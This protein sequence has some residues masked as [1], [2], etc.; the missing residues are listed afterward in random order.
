[1]KITEYAK[2]LLLAPNLEDKLLPPPKQWIDDSDQKSIRIETP[3]RNHKL[4]FSDKKIKIPRLEHLNLESN[5]GLTLHHFANHEL[6]AIELF[7]W[8]ILAFP[9]AQKSVRNGWVKTIEE[10]Q[11]HFKMYLNRMSEFGIQFGDIPL[12][13]I[14]WKQLDQFQSMESF[15]AVM[16]LSFEGA[17]LD[18]SQ[19]YAKVFSYFGDEKTSEI[20]IYIFEDEIKHVK[21]GVRAF[22]KS[23]PSEKNSW[24]HYLSLIQF[25]FTPRRAKGYLFFPE[26]R[27]LSGLDAN[28]VK[29][30]AEYEDEYTG[31][32]NL[33]S[34]KKF[35]LG[36][37][38]MRKKQA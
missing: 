5:R 22:E 26:T 30:L 31:R 29:Q 11:T 13:Y 28:F 8:A 19:V 23:I 16:S 37:E 7:A 38:L 35:G 2:H 20:M 4:Q 33:E 18:Y 21:R 17:N 25:P 32:V 3:G 9:D 14:F 34:V 24:E 15:S 6:M 12:N 27:F 36:S 10:E 1:M